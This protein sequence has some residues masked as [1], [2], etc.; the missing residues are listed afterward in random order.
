MWEFIIHV[1]A[2]EAQW[3]KSWLAK[4]AVLGLIPA[5]GGIL[6]NRK[7]DFIADSPSVSSNHSLDMTEILLE[8]T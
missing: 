7:W 3:V 5:E 2:P 4:L 1:V 6:S 8:A